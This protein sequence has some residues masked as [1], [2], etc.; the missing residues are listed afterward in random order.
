VQARCEVVGLLTALASTL[1]DASNP[2]IVFATLGAPLRL[3]ITVAYMYAA[4]AATAATDYAA[5]APFSIP[6][7]HNNTR[8]VSSL[9]TIRR[10]VLYAVKNC[11]TG[12]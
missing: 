10:A 5:V 12:Y 11:R 1:A 8:T 9:A 7:P 2:N 4:R 3:D 6:T